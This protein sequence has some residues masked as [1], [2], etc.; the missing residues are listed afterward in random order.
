MNFGFAT[1]AAGQW[2]ARPT[3]GRAGPRPRRA[4]IGSLL[5]SAPAPATAYPRA[6]AARPRPRRR[7][8]GPDRIR[9][10]GPLTVSKP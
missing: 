1:H 4:S 5:S 8:R 6:P 9:G 7:A 10:V 3:P 2:S